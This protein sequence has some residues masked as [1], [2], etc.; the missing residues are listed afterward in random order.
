[1]TRIDQFIAEYTQKRE[2]RNRPVPIDLLVLPAPV[3]PE[4]EE[5]LV[6]WNE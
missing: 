3:A 1:L 4:S 5:W 6:M 2:E